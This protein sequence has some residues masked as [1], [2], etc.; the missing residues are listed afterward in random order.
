M[1]K[2]K[3]SENIRNKRFSKEMEMYF[4][5][6][7]SILFLI[8]TVFTLKGLFSV[9]VFSLIISYFLY[10]MYKYFENK[11]NNKK[12]SSLLTILTMTLLI[13]VPFA[14]LSYFLILNIIKTTLQYNTYIENPQI[15]NDVFVSFLEKFTNSTVLSSINFSEDIFNISYI[16]IRSCKGI[17]L[18]Y[19]ASTILFFYDAFFN[20]LHSRL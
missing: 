19:S 17:F 11:I 4:I 3:T 6:S 8:L 20:V 1:T 13:F 12:L 7:A 15:L 10:P 5:I 16:C 9:I 2:K 18:I 14:L